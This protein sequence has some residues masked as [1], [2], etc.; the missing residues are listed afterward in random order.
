VLYGL[1]FVFALLDPRLSISIYILL[2]LY[3]ALPG[4]MVV[5]WITDR[6]AR[7]DKQRHRQAIPP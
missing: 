6:G 3:Y 4:P 5:R 7:M 1:A 2:L